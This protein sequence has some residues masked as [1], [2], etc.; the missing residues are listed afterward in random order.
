MDADHWCSGADLAML[1]SQ[2]EDSGVPEWAF[3]ARDKASLK[4][5]VGVG[6][7]GDGH[8]EGAEEAF[9]YAMHWVR[10]RV[11]RFFKNLSGYIFG[12]KTIFLSYFFRT[13]LVEATL[14]GTPPGASP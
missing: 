13:S 2:N 4:W 12:N 6:G 7:G 1:R 3:W 14:L 5:E 9:C 11:R 10:A 8:C